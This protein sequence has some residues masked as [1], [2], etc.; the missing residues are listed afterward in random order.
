MVLSLPRMGE[1][2]MMTEA[3]ADLTC[4]L[5]SDTSSCGGGREGGHRARSPAHDAYEPE[6][7]F[8]FCPRHLCSRGWLRLRGDLWLLRCPTCLG[9][10]DCASSSPAPIPKHLASGLSGL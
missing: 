8:C 6:P 4:W 3:S 1:R 5:A 9:F 10:S 2:P 7:R